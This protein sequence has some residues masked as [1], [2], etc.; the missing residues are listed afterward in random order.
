MKVLAI[1]FC[2]L[3]VGCSKP[4]QI[5]KSPLDPMVDIGRQCG[6]DWQASYL[7]DNSQGVVIDLNNKLM[8]MRHLVGTYWDRKE[9]KAEGLPNK[10]Q[11]YGPN[12]TYLGANDW[13][14]P[15]AE[16]ITSIVMTCDNTSAF[17]PAFS[18]PDIRT[19]SRVLTFPAIQLRSGSQ[20]T[21]HAHLDNILSTPNANWFASGNLKEDFFIFVRELTDDEYEFYKKLT[22]NEEGKGRI[23]FADGGLFI[24][25]TKGGRPHGKGVR[26]F[27]DGVTFYGK[28]EDGNPQNGTKIDLKTYQDEKR[29]VGSF[30][31]NW[32]YEA[33]NFEKRELIGLLKMMY[34]IKSNDYEITTEWAGRCVNG[35]ANGDGALVALMIDARGYEDQVAVIPAKM[36]HGKII[37]DL[38]AYTHFAGGR[39]ARSINEVTPWGYTLK[40]KKDVNKIIEEKERNAKSELAAWGAIIGFA[41]NTIKSMAEAANQ[42]RS[43]SVGGRAAPSCDSR[44]EECFKVIKE[45]WDDRDITRYE[46]E[47]TKG[48]Y[49]GRK[50]C[51]VFFKSDGTWSACGLGGGFSK[52]IRRETGNAI[53]GQ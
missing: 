46:I 28:F 9:G 22:T 31:K 27:R 13:R 14:K 50:E 17:A 7:L 47:C 4:M 15:S 48:V 24:G 8:W 39:N 49:A 12:R 1:V 19:L 33:C 38:I 41:K 51:L 42:P 26:I 18:F 10:Y 44:N 20:Q 45:Q 16:E 21:S 40:F 34:S 23:S 5:I 25:E 52:K 53:C 2:L 6:E 11:G 3:F 43:S 36:E 30:P 29:L 35:K 37:S 32:K